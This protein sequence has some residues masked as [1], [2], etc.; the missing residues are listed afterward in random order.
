VVLLAAAVAAQNQPSGRGA[1]SSENY[2]DIE[3]I[4]SCQVKESMTSVPA[5]ISQIPLLASG[6]ATPNFHVICDRK[7]QPEIRGEG[8]E[9]VLFE[10]R[11]GGRS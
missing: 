8:R 7:V 4:R 1:A 2:P 10:I 6:S 5:G 9:E 11:C 3:K